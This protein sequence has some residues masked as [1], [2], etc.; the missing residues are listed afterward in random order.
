MSREER[1][2]WPPNG[3]I[4]FD[5]EESEEEEPAPTKREPPTPVKRRSTRRASRASISPCVTVERGKEGWT[6][7]SVSGSSDVEIVRLLDDVREA[8]ERRGVRL[9]GWPGP[10]GDDPA[11]P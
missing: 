9:A 5:S 8:F 1:G 2:A 11:S 7:R 3:C 4:I 6:V 10:A